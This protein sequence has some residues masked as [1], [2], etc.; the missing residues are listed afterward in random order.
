M[1]ETERKEKHKV[2]EDEE[3]NVEEEH[4]VEEETK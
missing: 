2:R 4:E 3:G 1:S